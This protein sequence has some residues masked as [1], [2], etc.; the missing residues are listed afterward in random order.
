MITV[1]GH[2]LE[3]G[4]V[5]QL[6]DFFLRII[7]DNALAGIDECEIEESLDSIEYDMLH[8]DGLRWIVQRAYERLFK[9][10]PELFPFDLVLGGDDFERVLRDAYGAVYGREEM[11]FIEVMER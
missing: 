3:Q 2:V 7:A 11:N 10:K 9:A 1:H 4:Q 6:V 8:D 5:T